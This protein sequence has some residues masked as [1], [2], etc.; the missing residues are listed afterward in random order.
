MARNFGNWLK[1]YVEYTANSEAPTNMHFFAG[2]SAIA[3]ALRRH[4]WFDQGL[5]KW[6][7][8]FYIIN[9]AR[10]G[11]ATKS[12]SIN[13]AIDLLREV[14]GVHFGPNSMT[15]QAMIGR[16]QDAAELVEITPGG[17]MVPQACLTFA[18]SELGVLVDFYNRELVDALVDLWDGKT[19]SWEKLSKISGS[20]VIVNPWINII[21]GVTPSWLAANMPET[22]IGGGFASR[23]IFVYGSAKRQLVA[24]PKKH[25]AK[26]HKEITEKLIADLEQI[27]MMRGEF[28]LT[29]EAEAYGTK[30]YEQLW[31]HPPEHLQTERLEGYM[32]RK[33]THLHKLMM[34]LS[35]AERDDR[36]LTVEH[37]QMAEELLNSV[38][39]DM[40]LAL[41]KVGRNEASL[42]LETF[43]EYVEKKGEVSYTDCIRYLSRYSDM[44][45]INFTLQAA[46][47]AGYVLQIQKGA[48]LIIRHAA[49]SR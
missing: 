42:T 44:Q 9:V 46:I 48:D 29:P 4:V 45:G 43:V 8:N 35:A 22:A 27:S 38:E 37:F 26:N 21:A 19:G 3:G 39:N 41:D 28:V 24:Y 1:T 14:P 11:I 36:I 47:A 6:F 32:A 2:V 10:P 31:T 20:E 17:D 49:M 5:F 40:I 30:W 16:M 12:T 25:Q 15:W 33:Q 13:L 34:V 7:P 18:A 23:C